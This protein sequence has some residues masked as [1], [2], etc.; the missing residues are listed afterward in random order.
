MTGRTKAVRGT[1]RSLT[2]RG[3]CL[4]AGGITAGFAGF[5][6]HERDLIRVAVLLIVLPLVAVAFAARTRFRLTC[7]RRLEPARIQA[8]D[9]A[10]VVLRIE[11]VSRLPTGLLLIEDTIPYLLGGRPRVVVDR[12]APR[13]PIDVG[14]HVSGELRGRYT[15]GP[16]TVRLMDPFA[17]CELPRA[18]ATT[19]TLVVTPQVHALP[20]VTLGGEWGGAGHSTSRAVA[21]HGDDDVATREYRQRSCSTP[22]P[23]R[24]GARDLLPPSSGRSRPLH[25]S[26]CTSPAEGSR[27]GW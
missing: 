4:V 17:L 24:T 14:Y 15:V 12:L 1:L 11:N 22:A 25:R 26:A 19:D 20:T 21:T 8:G 3:R 6:F 10:R 23:V 18:F 2:I 27:P 5:L 13:R 16:L 7:T 9:K